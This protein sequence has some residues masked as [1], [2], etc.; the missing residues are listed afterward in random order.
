MSAS[1]ANLNVQN[2]N[3]N[4][5]DLCQNDHFDQIYFYLTNLN[6]FWSNKI[7]LNNILNF[8]KKVKFHVM[9][10]FNKI[11]WDKL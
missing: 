5:S 8:I 2:A 7:N 4:I 10:A 11:K 9:A 1:P 6:D 3:N